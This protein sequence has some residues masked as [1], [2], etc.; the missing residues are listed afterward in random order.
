MNATDSKVFFGFDPKWQ[1]KRSSKTKS[2]YTYIT[3]ATE[4]TVVFKCLPD[5]LKEML[6]YEKRCL[7]E[8]D[9]RQQSFIHNLNTLRRVELEGER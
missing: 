8:M 3:S 7:E 6:K 2:E 1:S 9:Q 4:V 5:Q